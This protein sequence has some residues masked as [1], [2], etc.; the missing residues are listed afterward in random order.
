[1]HKS[2]QLKVAKC[3]EMIL[4]VNLPLSRLRETHP[5]HFSAHPEPPRVPIISYRIALVRY[6]VKIA[7]YEGSKVEDR[8]LPPMERRRRGL[9]PLTPLRGEGWRRL[10][11]GLKGCSSGERERCRQGCRRCR[12]TRTYHGVTPISR[13]GHF[14]LSPRVGLNVVR[15]ADH[16]HHHPHLARS[17]KLV[18][19]AIRP[20]VRDVKPLPRCAHTHCA[21]PIR[22]VVCAPS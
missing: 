10:H 14:A 9:P 2:R 20:G 18:G 13:C 1:M 15:K 6:G 12:S 3:R 5:A 21:A 4:K 11:R 16:H 8:G 19:L 22:V 17:L 7:A